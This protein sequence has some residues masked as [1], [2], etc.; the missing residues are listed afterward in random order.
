MAKQRWY[1]ATCTRGLE[2]VLADELRALDAADVR[3]D[4]GGVSFRGPAVL[5]YRV[6]LWSR[7]AIRVF[8]ELVRGRVTDADGLYAL[9][10]GVPWARFLRPGQTFAVSANVRDNPAFRHDHFVALK[11]KDAVVD[12]LRDDQGNRPDVDPSAPDVPLMAVIRGQAT[13]ISRDLAGESLH[14]RGWRPVQHKSPLNEALAAGLLLLSDWDRTSPLADPMC[15]SGTLLVEA[16]HLAGD[17][18]PGLR[19]AFAFERWADRDRAGWDALRADAEARWEAGRQGL[20]ALF[21]ND[22]HDGAVSIARQALV[23]ADIA[24]AVRLTCGE[25]A[26]WRP[27]P[28]GWVVTNPPWGLRLE[29]DPTSSWADLG[30]WLKAHAPGATAWIL[31]GEG[32]PVDALRM[33]PTRRIPVWAG[34]VECRWLRVPVNPGAAADAPGTP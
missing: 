33:R 26:R 20:P 21:G 14:R 3:Q 1:F 28:V 9:A 16:A 7:T 25:V 19:R 17:R 29:D 8:E 32:S 18:A 13:T 11:V 23:D 10:G 6:C 5:G 12:A 4:P 15:G 22:R 24:H 34:P 27:P 2:P 31:A 30:G